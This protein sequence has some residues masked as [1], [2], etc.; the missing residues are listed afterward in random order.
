MA[1]ERTLGQLVAEASQDLSELV[2]YEMALAKAEIK[3]DVVKGAAAGGMFG[4]AGYLGLLATVTLVITAGYGLDAAG[5]SPWLSFLIV[6]GALL[7]LAGIL[8]LIG[9]L[10]LKRIRP[11]ERTIATTKL[12]IA[13]VK[14]ARSNGAGSAT[15]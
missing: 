13:A 15:G 12:T 2:R 7:L 11:P 4:V 8:A 5:L 3:D 1:E 9:V 14:G 10:L 6:S